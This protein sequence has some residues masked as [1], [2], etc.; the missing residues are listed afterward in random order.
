MMNK[1]LLLI[2]RVTAIA[3]GLTL[4]G[5]CCLDK[6]FNYDDVTP[7]PVVLDSPSVVG[8]IT[9]KAGTP[10]VGAQVQVGSYTA[11]TD[12]NGYYIVQNV[13]PGSYAVTISASGYIKHL[14]SVTVT[15]PDGTFV[16]VK[17]STTLAAIDNR[18]GINVTAGGTAKGT[19]V[20]EHLKA[21]D[22]A[23]ISI[24]ATVQSGTVSKD[25]VF[26]L[27]P[28]YDESQAGTETKADASEEE[29]L[30]IGVTL[31]S[32]DPSVALK[33]PVPIELVCDEALTEQ[34][35]VRHLVGDTWVNM[36]FQASNGVITIMATEL[37][38]YALF[39]PFVITE[40]PGSEPLQLS[41]SVWDNL[42]GSGAI[43]AEDVT[44]SY[45]SGTR[46]NSTAHDVLSAL[47]IE[48]LAYHYG[49]VHQVMEGVFPLD[50][51]LPIGTRL[52]VTGT[53]EVTE[54]VVSYA[55][56]S[57]NGTYFGDTLISAKTTNRQHNGGS[58]GQY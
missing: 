30:L 25:V 34:I 37:G 19:I 54:T 49:A 16:I 2:L 56:W 45:S 41:R 52:E 20:S 8:F 53:Q 7:P 14:G 43:T 9:D 3:V 24:T 36:E 58:G 50:I 38:S 32:D 23:G 57:V 46:I 33:N 5:S 18:T 47:L 51:R 11:A 6:D 17:Y 29:R 27:I 40:H 42:Y 21:N 4:C 1:T 28:I 35:S 15:S 44:F 55:T 39:L 31:T 10:I 12:A 48:K 13:T 26:Y 22:P